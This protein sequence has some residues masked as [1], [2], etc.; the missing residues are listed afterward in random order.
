M[1]GLIPFVY[2]TIIHYTNGEQ[3]PIG[4]NPAFNES[5][6]NSYMRLAGDSGRFQASEIIH[7]FSPPPSG[8]PPV[9]SAGAQQSPRWR[10]AASGIVAASG[11]AAQSP[12]RRPNSMARRQA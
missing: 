10:P 8:M 3:T 7:I 12:R 6:S 4:G 5:P 1:E 9:A 2:R 11:G